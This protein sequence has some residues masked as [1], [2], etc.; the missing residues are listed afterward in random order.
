[1]TKPADP[2]H[3]R[4]PAKLT[5][6]ATHGGRSV[7]AASLLVAA[8][9]LGVVWVDYTATRSE[10]LSLLREQATSL[11]QTVAAAARSNRE[12]GRQ[13]ETQITA[14]LLDNARLLAELDRRGA[15]SQATLDEIVQ[16]HELFRVSVLASDGSLEIASAAKGHPR[17]PGGFG[18]GRGRGAGPGRGLGAGRG[19]GFGAGGGGTLGKRLISGEETE[20]VEELHESRGFGGAHVAAGVRRA[21][22]G[23]IVINVD[24]SGVASLQRQASLDALLADIVESASDVAYVVFETDGLRLAHGAQ[25]EDPPPPAPTQTGS[26]TD[27]R[28]VV[29]GLEALEL[30]GPIELEEGATAHLRLGMSLEGVRRA[31]GRMLLQLAFS[32]LAS[33]ALAGL[34]L[35]T[36]LLRHKYGLLSEQHARAEEALRRR[37][38][39]AAMGE[40]ASTVAHEVRN[41]LNAVAMSIQRLRREFASSV[42]VAKDREELEELLDVLAGETDRINRIVQQFLDFARPP[43]LAPKPTELSALIQGVTRAA[44]SR[45]G[46]RDVSLRCDV[47]QAGEAILDPDQI[48]QAIDNLVRNA[49]E[50][51]A[52]GGEVVVT[53]RSDPDGHAIEVADTGRGIEPEDLSRIFNLYFTTRPDGTGVGLAVTQQIVTAHAGTIEVDSRPGRGTR[54]LVRLPP[55]L[56][57]VNGG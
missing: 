49:L 42:A 56:P 20:A 35:G 33:L 21:N 13:T 19:R 47:S 1:V 10:L 38:R 37:D 4:R 15:L 40:L 24:A 53:A 7:L 29:A 28:V 14:R 9:L 27:R 32:L 25:P 55:S 52:A 50:A 51:T 18:G 26:M 31:E 8:G 48:R 45:A 57:E 11:G 43:R 36:V 23:A 6:W 44:E 22:G 46:S 5:S 17:Q 34:G 2:E 30:A 41:P 39:L 12:A 54:I 3:A 16:R